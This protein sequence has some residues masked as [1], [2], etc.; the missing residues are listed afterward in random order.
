MTLAEHVDQVFDGI[1]RRQRASNGQKHAKQH[2]DV[3]ERMLADI[4]K[5]ECERAVRIGRQPRIMC[6]GVSD[7]GGRR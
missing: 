4:A 3:R 2:N 5:Q 6:V 1:L 7:R